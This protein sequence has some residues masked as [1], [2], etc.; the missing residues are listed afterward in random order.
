[1]GGSTNVVLH[2][3]ELA[4]AAGIDFWREVITQDEFNRVSRTLPVL[5]NARPFGRYSMVDIDAKGGLPVIVRELL[6]AGLL[7]GTCLTCTG[8]TL[9]GQVARLSPVDLTV[10]VAEPT[11][12]GISVYRQWQGYAAGYD[13]AVVVAGNKVQ[14]EQDVAF[15]R[16]ETGTDLVTWLGHE[17]AIRAMEQGRPFSLSDLSDGTSA[18]LGVLKDTLDARPRDWSRYARQAAEFHVRNARAR[19]WAAAAGED[20]AAQI[21][22]GFTLGR[23]P[24]DARPVNASWSQG[25]G[26]RSRPE[27]ETGALCP[28]RPHGQPQLR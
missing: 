22:P 11:R 10:L 18:A 20:L 27:R 26:S 19:A 25:E 7:E 1:M 16:S 24:P 14:T 8:E 9:A 2:A 15:L 3:P 23:A 21:A 5:V 13:V 4:R 6:S 12:K 28:G 17:P